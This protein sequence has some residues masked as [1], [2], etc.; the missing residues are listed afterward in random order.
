ME[1]NDAFPNYEVLAQHDEATGVHVRKKLM[2]VFWLLLVVT[3]IEVLIGAFWSNF[4][5]AFHVSKTWLMIVFIGFTLFKAGYIIMT[6]MHLGDENKSL[7]WTILGPYC[8][9][10]V[11]LLY[12]VTVTEGSYTQKYR[13]LLDPALMIK[14]EAPKHHEE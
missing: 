10:V 5:D 9:F 13:A 3:I 8:A 4:R 7:R 6:F 14:K 2:N 11:Y 12:M 1:F